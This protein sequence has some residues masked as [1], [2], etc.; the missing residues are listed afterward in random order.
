MIITTFEVTKIHMV[1]C[2]FFLNENY[3]VVISGER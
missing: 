2:K 3:N 1:L